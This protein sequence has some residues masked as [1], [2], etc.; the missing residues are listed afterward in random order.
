MTVSI[1]QLSGGLLEYDGEIV[2]TKSKCIAQ[3]DVHVPLLCFEEGKIELG[4]QVRIISEVV[5]RRWYDRLIN[6]EKA[7]YAFNSAGCTQ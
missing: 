2:S 4:I 7:C 5:Y 6:G 3:G 1:A